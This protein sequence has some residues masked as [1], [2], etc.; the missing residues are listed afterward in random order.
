MQLKGPAAKALLLRLVQASTEEDVTE[1]LKSS[2]YWTDRSV[3]QPIGGLG[4]NRAVVGNQ[5]SS[6]VAALVE[7]LVNSVDAVLTGECLRQGIDP[8]GPQAPASMHEAVEEFFDVPDGRIQ[9]LNSSQ[10]TALASHIL[11]VATGTRDHPNY[12]VIDDGEGQSPKLFPDTFLSLLREN[13]SKIPFVQGKFDMGGTGVLQFTG[14]NSFQLILSRRQPDLLKESDDRSDEASGW[15]FALV[16]RIDPVRD[17]P[18]STYVF[19]APGNAIPCFPGDPLQLKPGPFPDATGADM[20]A[21]TLIK[22][23]NYKFPGRLKSPAT[24]DLFYELREFLQDPALPVRILE[25]RPLYTAHTHETTL[26]GL[27]ASLPDSRIEIEPGFDT[28]APL[29][30]PGVGL[31]DLRL[32]AWA[33]VPAGSSAAGRRPAGVFFNVNG[34]LHGRFDKDFVRRRTNFE[35]LAP[36]LM[37]MVDCSEL[38]VRVREDL[39]H[40]SRD[41]IRECEERQQLE[42]AIIDYIRDHPGLREL[43]ARRREAVMKSAL[44]EEDTAKIIENLIKSDPTLAALFGK[45]RQIRGPVGGPVGPPIVFEGRPYPTYFKS[46]QADDGT[47]TKQCPRNRSCRIDFETDAAN[48]Y[49]SRVREPGTMEVTGSINKTSLHLWNGRASVRLV[50]PSSSSPGDRINARISVTDPSRSSPFDTTVVLELVADS[51]E[52]GGEDHERHPPHGPV[53]SG[54]PHIVEVRRDQWNENTGFD[55][56]TSIRLKNAPDGSLDVLVNMD[57]SYLRGEILRRKSTPPEVLNYSFKYGLLLLA[58]GMLERARRA[59][60]ETSEST[61]K[62]GEP[63]APIDLDKFSEPCDGLAIT[64]IPVILNLGKGKAALDESVAKG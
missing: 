23:W 4:N 10:R 60:Q 40:A 7:K 45:G 32:V 63:S 48:D 13:K 30:V 59:T 18:Q 15:G 22:L 38:P 35:Y 20:A 12:T 27:S 39:F 50:P 42:D 14:S 53:L 5:Q 43:N 16:R 58:L 62:N 54:L 55:G 28:G 6:P 11:L 47:V 29:E 31:V 44:S 3:W 51:P 19:L 64:L 36:S 24:L 9:N 17:Q 2:G 25:R 34:Q 46:R 8:T 61:P 1:L 21:G 41:R 57:N 37:V 26:S 33:E 52:S 56:E 49:F